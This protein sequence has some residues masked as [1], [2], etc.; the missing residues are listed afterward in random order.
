MRREKAKNTA[1]APKMTAFLFGRSTWVGWDEAAAGAPTTVFCGTGSSR[2]RLSEAG[3][4]TVTGAAGGLGD[5]NREVI[6]D[7]V[8]VFWVFEK[9]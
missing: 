2:M 8:A 1:P 5:E 4:G 9:Q 6:H 7:I 3:D